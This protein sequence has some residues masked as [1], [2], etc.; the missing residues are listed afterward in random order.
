MNYIR[1]FSL[2]ALIPLFLTGCIANYPIEGLNE[3]V[4][5]G[6]ALKT[7]DSYPWGRGHRF[8]VELYSVNNKLLQRNTHFALLPANTP[9]N[10][11]FHCKH[12]LKGGNSYPL[13]DGTVID[14]LDPNK[15]Y[16][17]TGDKI[18]YDHSSWTIT[19]TLTGRK[20]IEKTTLKLNNYARFCK[21]MKFIEIDCGTHL[22]SIPQT[23]QEESEIN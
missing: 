12:T 14:Q 11:R 20:H 18:S 17:V 7:Y 13:R 23:P 10:F 19:D 8:T 21:T 16:K 4:V 1:V 5:K 2:G 9:L 3:S 6:A 22:V 15:C